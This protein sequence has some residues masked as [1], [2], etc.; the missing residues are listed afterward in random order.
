M[1]KQLRYPEKIE[2]LKTR[3]EIT[4]NRGL[5]CNWRFDRSVP[6]MES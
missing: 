2:L 4:N 5:F 1:F 3:L 6:T